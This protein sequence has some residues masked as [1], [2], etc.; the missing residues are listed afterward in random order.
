M[1]STELIHLHRV[2]YHPQLR[3]DDAMN[4]EIEIGYGYMTMS[5]GIL[6]RCHDDFLLPQ[7]P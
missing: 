6:T 4:Y 3:D 1:H 7:C 2:D 5:V